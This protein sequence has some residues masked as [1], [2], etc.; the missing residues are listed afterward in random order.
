MDIDFTLPTFPKSQSNGKQD[1]KDVPFLSRRYDEG[2]PGR[3]HIPDRMYFKI[4]EVADIVGV[5]AYVLRYWETE[6]SQIK[7]SKTSSGQRVY[8]K[9]DVEWLLLIKRLLYKEKFSIE[10]VRRKIKDLT[11]NGQLKEEKKTRLVIDES[12]AKKL[13]DIRNELVAIMDLCKEFN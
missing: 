1:E 4:G 2:D 9:T 8:K 6:F 11:K 3:I 13:H 7:P 10:G 12:K 5:K